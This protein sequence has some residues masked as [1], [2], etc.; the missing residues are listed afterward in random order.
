MD[1]EKQLD[2]LLS[3]NPKAYFDRQASNVLKYFTHLETD[4]IE[5]H[6]ANELFHGI[7]IGIP[8]WYFRNDF[9][10][11]QTDLRLDT[12]TNLDQLSERLQG[13]Y[14]ISIKKLKIELSLMDIYQLKESGDFYWLMTTGTDE[15]S[16]ALMLAPRASIIYNAW[17]DSL[18]FLT[19]QN[20][21][22]IVGTGD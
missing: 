17:D 15:E 13:L 1:L 20:Q 14:Q 3:N 9:N 16:K 22:C 21:N 10:F 19:Q 4:V 18:N 12:V 6:V 11:L 2:E 5:E 7:S 8:P